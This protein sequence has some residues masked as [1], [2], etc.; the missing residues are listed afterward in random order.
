MVADATLVSLAAVRQ[1]VKN[2][3]LVRALRDDVDFDEEWYA[4]AA[5]RELEELAGEAAAE[6]ARLREVR[7]ATRRR[8]GVARA[9]D[10][11]RAADSRHLKRRAR[12]LEELV[13]ELRRLMQ[14]DT[15][16]STLITEA[17]LRAL[18]EITAT[19]ASVP[20]LGRERAATGIARSRALQ[21][22][23]EELSDYAD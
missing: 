20:G 5:R 4:D 22:L 12:V 19:T 18:D 2:V 10:D 6:A 17:R 7:E 21:S 16:V 9:A 14:D 15:T 1:A 23:R 8:R 11:Y 3:M 13:E